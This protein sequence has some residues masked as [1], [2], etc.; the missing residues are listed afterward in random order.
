MTIH[1]FTILCFTLVAACSSPRINTSSDEAMKASITAV[2]EALTQEQ[3]ARFDSALQVLAFSQF[4]LGAVFTQPAAVTAGKLETDVKALLNGKTG[5]QVIAAADSII[6]ARDAKEMRELEARKDSAD[7][8]RTDMQRF[9][10]VRSRFYKRPSAFGLSD[11]IVELTVRNG[12]GHAISRAYFLG[13]LASP[14]RSVPW[15]KDEFSYQIRGGLEPG[16]EASWRL[17]LNMFG[18]WGSVKAPSEA[19]LT[20][21]VVRLD[22][23]D[24]NTLY[25]STRFD[26]KDAQK[27]ATLYAKYGHR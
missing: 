16:E 2:R 8:A 23:A 21:E 1:R 11:P 3:R 27:L 18:D 25:S 13:T 5:A 4:D 6:R 15:V 20:V 7:R 9:V 24:G 10:V 22:G 26:D 19:I 12:T 17:S 14:G